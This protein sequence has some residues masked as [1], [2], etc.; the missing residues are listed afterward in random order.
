MKEELS[1]KIIKSDIGIVHTEGVKEIQYR[2]RHHRRTAA[3]A[4][5]LGTIRDCI[6]HMISRLALRFPHKL[7]FAGTP[8]QRL[9]LRSLP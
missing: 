3:L 8:F 9:P 7:K 2:L 1:P 5:R 4:L 6:A